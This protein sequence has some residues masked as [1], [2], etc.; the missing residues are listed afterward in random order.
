MLRIWRIPNRLPPRGFR[1]KLDKFAR[2]ELGGFENRGKKKN[3]CRENLQDER[4]GGRE[5]K[6]D[7]GLGGPGHPSPALLRRRNVVACERM[8]S[9]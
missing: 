3:L 4:E 1:E 8:P 7:I 9:G 5:G 2:I 6:R